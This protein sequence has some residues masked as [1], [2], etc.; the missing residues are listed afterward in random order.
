MNYAIEWVDEAEEHL[1][2]AWVACADR[3]AVAEAARR[4]EQKLAHNPQELGESRSECD[5]ILF[6]PPLA[7]FY[8][9]DEPNRKVTV[10]SV[11]LLPR[12]A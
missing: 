11:A 4:A 12:F 1:A 9:V 3:A 6:E 2:A 8:R 10:S 5:R 7:I